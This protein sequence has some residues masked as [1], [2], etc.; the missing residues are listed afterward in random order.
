[1]NWFR[2]RNKDISDSERDGAFKEL[3]N[4]N[5]YNFF[6]YFLQ[7]LNVHGLICILRISFII[8]YNN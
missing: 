4:V 1:M 2:F 5:K 3:D 6:S 7:Q 8:K